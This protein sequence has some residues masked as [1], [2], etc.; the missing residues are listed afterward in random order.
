[1]AS[2][3]LLTTDVDPILG[4]LAPGTALKD[5]QDSLCWA[6][7]DTTG[8]PNAKALARWES[9]VGPIGLMRN[10]WEGGESFYFSESFDMSY[11]LDG[12]V[13][14]NT[15]EILTRPVPMVSRWSLVILALF[16]VSAGS[17]VIRQRTAPGTR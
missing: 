3:L 13:L 5:C 9:G 7:A 11:T 1:M 15:M 17:L 4:D 8:H 16:V 10:T 6:V 2:D 12:E 14:L